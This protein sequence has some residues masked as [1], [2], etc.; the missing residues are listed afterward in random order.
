MV[1]SLS[2][3]RTLSSYFSLP[4]TSLCLTALW[5]V[6]GDTDGT[7]WDASDGVKRRKEDVK[8]EV[9]IRRSPICCVC[10]VQIFVLSLGQNWSRFANVPFFFCFCLLN[11][12][13]RQ[14]KLWQ[15]TLLCLVLITLVGT[16][17]FVSFKCFHDQNILYIFPPPLPGSV[18][19][20]LHIVANRIAQMLLLNFLSKGF[21]L[22]TLLLSSLEQLLTLT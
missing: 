3:Y 5:C 4:F 7:G 15:G 20:I 2:I 22:P 19:F 18:G 9:W 8:K 1:W 17:G 11:G 10:C 14:T 12:P 16:L 6:C 21:R 13:T